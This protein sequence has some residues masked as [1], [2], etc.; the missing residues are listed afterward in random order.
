MTPPL[1]LDAA[2]LETLCEQ[3]PTEAVRALLAEAVRR[4]GEVVVPTVVCAELC[5]GVARTRSV[6]AALGRH[7]RSRG[8]LPALTR[9]DTD[10]VLARQVGAILHATGSGSADVVDA[11]VV[12]VCVLAGGGVVVT[13]DPE[14]IER[15]ADA[16][17]AVRIVTR[18]P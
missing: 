16:V 4:D 2:G 9:A 18:R 15:L 12:A 13:A 11:H 10:F 14:D 7:D 8:E 1:V 3:V 17:P 5:R 6:E